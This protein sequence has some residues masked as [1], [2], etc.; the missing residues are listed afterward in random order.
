[1]S[2][3]D[4]GALGEF[5]SSVVVLITLVYLAIQ[6]R[7]TKQATQAN[8]QWTRANASRDLQ[9]MWAT[10]PEAANLIAEFGTKVD[11]YPSS[12]EFDPMRFRYLAINRAVLDVL[13]AFLL[14]AQSKQDKELAK[15]RIKFQMQIPG[16]RASWPH[17]RQV[18]MFYPEFIELV[19]EALAENDSADA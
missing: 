14:S 11:H 1:M 15:D 16:F 6:T 17:I 4:L 9:I 19:E 18:G 7:Q 8:L 13:Q 12:D 2:I 5:L 3:Q 10:H